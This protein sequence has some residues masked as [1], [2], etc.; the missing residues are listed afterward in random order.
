MAALLDLALSILGL[1]CAL[2]AGLAL[3]PLFLPANLWT[4]R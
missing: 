3:V 4:G 1:A 2:E